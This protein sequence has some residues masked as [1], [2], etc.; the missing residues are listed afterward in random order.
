[1]ADGENGNAPQVG[2]QALPASKFKCVVQTC[3]VEIA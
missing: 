1:M 3:G 2:P